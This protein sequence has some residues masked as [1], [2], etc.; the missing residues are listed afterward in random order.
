M[1]GEHV[2][3]RQGRPPDPCVGAPG[4]Q[5]RQQFLERSRAVDIPGNLQQGRHK[6]RIDVQ[7]LVL[8]RRQVRTDENASAHGRGNVGGVSRIVVRGW[9]A[10]GRHRAPVG[11]EHVVVRVEPAVKVRPLAQPERVVGVWVQP[12]GTERAVG[13][14]GA[15]GE[16]EHAL[17]HRMRDLRFLEPAILHGGQQVLQPHVFLR[18]ELV[19]E[20]HRRDPAEDTVADLVQRADEVL[21]AGKLREV[22]LHPRLLAED[23]IGELPHGKRFSGAGWPEHTDGEGPGRVRHVAVAPH[24]PPDVAE[25]LNLPAIGGHELAEARVRQ[26]LDRAQAAH[27]AL[28]RQAGQAL[29]AAGGEQRALGHL[30]DTPRAAVGDLIWREPGDGGRLERRAAAADHGGEPRGRE[31]A[32]R[33]DIG[34]RPMSSR[35]QIPHRRQPRLNGRLQIA[36]GCAAVEVQ[37]EPPDDRGRKARQVPGGVPIHRFTPF[38]LGAAGVEHHSRAPFRRARGALARQPESAV[39][40]EGHHEMSG[41]REWREDGA[42]EECIA[43]VL[44]RSLPR[45]PTADPDVIGP[46]RVD[47]RHDDRSIQP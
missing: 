37:C 24:E 40:R 28:A 38:A 17:A 3:G 29:C 15:P 22:E 9:P 25:C 30:H 46:Q 33:S 6:A 13:C 27:H 23:I 10:G 21:R 45:Q 41:S 19:P 2:G 34:H 44:D 5:A 31:A 12:L 14:T 1:H 42:G 11:A 32:G 26:A 47:G 43:Y 18:V 39:G 35:M 16:D 20:D 7:R 36:L 4:F 8:R